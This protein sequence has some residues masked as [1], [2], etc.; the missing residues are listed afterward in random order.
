M[1]G[2]VGGVGRINLREYLI[3]G[4]KKLE[5]R[6]YDSAGIAYAEDGKVIL[7]KVAGRVSS[8]DA[9]VP[10]SIRL[11]ASPTPAG[12][13]MANP[14]PATPIPIS[15]TRSSSPS[16]ITASSRTSAP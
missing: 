16:S 7:E 10:T 8:L 15:R 12:R 6:G 5:Y 1:C 11:S 4:L 3:S 13:P 9:I 2:I 14:I